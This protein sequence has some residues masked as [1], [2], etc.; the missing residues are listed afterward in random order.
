VNKARPGILVTRAAEQAEPLCQQI[1]QQGW[2]AL[3]FPVVEIKP[4]C[5]AATR[6]RLQQLHDYDWL[7][8]ISQ[9][10]VRFFPQCC[11]LQ[12]AEHTR[13]STVGKATSKAARQVGFNVRLQPEQRYD[14]ESLLEAPQLRDVAGQRILIVRG[15]GGREL[16]ADSLRQRRAVVDYAEVYERALPHS[17]IT[18]LVNNWQQVDCISVTSNAL[19]DNLVTLLGDALGQQL[20]GKPLVVISQRMLEHAQH[21]GFQKIGLAQAAADDEIIKTIRT[22]L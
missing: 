3:R 20:I 19:L 6:Q 16:L 14:S 5:D 12:P 17:D 13:I 7:I 15:N 21:L 1:E 4:R 18:E 8:F 2:R 10:A 11:A 22:M 9:N